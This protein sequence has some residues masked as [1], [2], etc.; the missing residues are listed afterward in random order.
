MAI[1]NNTSVRRA[2]LVLVALFVLFS[3]KSCFTS[4]APY[5]PPINGQFNSPANTNYEEAVERGVEPDQSKSPTA[6]EVGRETGKAYE[7]LKETGKEFWEGAK[8]GA[9]K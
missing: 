6:R 7:N 8:T 3:L 1:M 4:P 9:N 2:S 5:E